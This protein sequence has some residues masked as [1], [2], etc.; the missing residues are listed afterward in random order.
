MINKQVFD[1]KADVLVADA[2]RAEA[3]HA[4]YHA[5]NREIKWAAKNTK[6]IEVYDK[7]SSIVIEVN[8]ELNTNGY[9]SMLRINENDELILRLY[10]NDK[11]SA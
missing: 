10:L 8:N 5:I 7:Q 2:V 1:E 3:K 4:L 6:Y 11:I 9:A